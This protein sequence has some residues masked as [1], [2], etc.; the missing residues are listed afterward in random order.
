MELRIH[1]LKHFSVEC[2]AVISSHDQKIQDWKGCKT[3]KDA[4][5]D[6]LILSCIIMKE[7]FVPCLMERMMIGLTD[8]VDRINGR[9]VI[10]QL[11]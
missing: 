3:G 8:V 4:R 10:E 1:F 11:V 6:S 7:I 5:L 2:R 9:L